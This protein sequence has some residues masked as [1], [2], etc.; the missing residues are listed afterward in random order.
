MTF[1][2]RIKKNYINFKKNILFYSSVITF[3]L[4]YEEHSKEM[5]TLAFN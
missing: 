1:L 5:L 4:N 2:R 3:T